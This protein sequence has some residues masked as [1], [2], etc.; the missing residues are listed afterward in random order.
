MVVYQHRRL[1]TND[2]FYVGI[3]RNQKRAHCKK[4]R[5]RYWHN[6]TNKIEFSV[7]IIKI[8][9]TWEEACELEKSLILKYG[10]K[11]LGTGTLVNL[12]NGGEGQLNPSPETRKKMSEWQKGKPKS[13]ETK[14]KLSASAKGRK[15][16]EESKLKMSLSSMKQERNGHEKLVLNLETGIFYKSAKEAFNYSGFKKSLSLFKFMLSNRVENKTS[17]IYV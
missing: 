13:E 12:T 8:V 17:L 6:I 14:L 10:R 5:N 4:D 7:E 16:T 15:H 3:G 1:D 9:D 11:D 2:I